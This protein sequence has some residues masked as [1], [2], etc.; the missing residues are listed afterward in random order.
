MSHK[1]GIPRRT[2]RERVLSLFLAAVL[3]LGMAPELV[4]PASADHWADAYL[5][6][7]VDWGVMRADQI[8]NPDARLTRA[9]FMAIVNRAYGYKE[10]GPMPF[11]DVLPTDWFY[12]DVAIAYTAGYMGGTSDN[13]ASPNNVLTREMAVCILARNMMMKDTPGE[14]LTFAD[15][16]DISGWAKGLVKTAVDNYIVDGY[17]DNRFGPQDAITKGQ[18]AA[19]VTRCVG[20]PLNEPGSYS[21]GDVFGNVTVTSPNVTLRNTTI[22]GDLYVSGGVGLGGVLLENVKVLGR[23]IVSGTGESEEGKAS[24]IM[25]NVSA[26]EL[27]VDNMRNRYVTVRA[28][29]VTEIAKT[30][31]RTNAYL[32]DNNTDTKGLM[33]ITLEGEPG[34]RLDLAGRIKTVVDKTP[35]S[36]IQVAKGAVQ[37]ITVDEKATNAVIQLNRNTEVKE[38]NLDVAAN[39]NGEGDIGKLNVNAPGST[40]TMLPDDI[41][42]RPGITGN[43]NG[44]VMDSAAAEES[45]LDPRLLSGFPVASD[46]AP[47][48]FRAD[49]SCNKR[50]TVYWAV[51]NI[52]DGSVGAE[53]L[54]HP[55]AYGSRAIRSG[56]VAVPAGNTTVSTQVTGLTVGGSYYLSAVMVDGRDRRSPVKVIS[57]T[58]PDNSVP[59][60]AQG[61]P[62]MSLITDSMAQVTVMPTKTCKLYYAVLPKGAMAPTVNDMRS[63]SVVGNLGYGIVDVV[64]NT[65]RVINVSSRLEELKDYTLYLWL[66]DADGA[67]SSA[68]I[69]V[70][71]RTVDM[72]PPRFVIAPHE[73]GPVQAT[74]VPL[75][76]ALNEAGIIYWAVVAEGDVYPKYNPQNPDDNE[77]INGNQQAKLDSDYAKLQVSTGMNALR[78]GRV[79]AQANT[80]VA[81]N[82]TGLQA[83]KSYDLYYVARDTAGN[84]SVKVEK[85]TIHTLDN[86]RPVARQYFSDYSGQDN[87]QNPMPNTDIILEF[88]ESVRSFVDVA[89]ED[90]TVS[91]KQS[92]KDLY[93]SVTADNNPLAKALQDCVML[94]Q[95]TGNGRP[96]PVKHKYDPKD[97]SDDWVIDFTKARV[98]MDSGKMLLTFPKDSLKLASG[99]TYYFRLSNIKDTSNA[100]N[101]IMPNPVTY[102]NMADG[103]HKI[104]R[105]TTVFAQVSLNNLNLGAA[106]APVKDGKAVNLDLT[107]RMSPQSTER[108]HERNSYDLYLWS[109]TIL[110][111]NLYYRIVKEDEP[112]TSTVDKKYW[113]GDDSN[114]VGTP[115]SKGWLYLGASGEVNPQN[116]EMAGKSLNGDFNGLK[117]KTFPPLKNLG[118]EYDYEFVIELTEMEGSTVR[119]TWNGQ[120]YFDIYAAAGV[121]STLVTLSRGL[122]KDRWEEYKALGLNNGG[123]VSIGISPQD[124]DYLRIRQL[125]TD[126]KL[127]EFTKTYPSFAETDIGDTFATIRLN[128]DRAGKIYYVVAPVGQITTTV[129]DGN[130]EYSDKAA[131]DWTGMSGGGKGGKP[132]LTDMGYTVSSP[133][134][135][136]IYR[137]TEYSGNSLIQTGVVEY[138][139]GG[140]TYELVLNASTKQSLQPNT[141]Y[142]AYFVVQGTAQEYSDV[143]CYKFKTTMVNRP[144]IMLDEAGGGLVNVNTTNV[145]GDLDYVI[146]TSA[147]LNL[148]ASLKRPL[149][150][151]NA[152]VLPTAYEDYTVLDAILNTYYDSNARAGNKVADAYFA[153]AG[154]DGYSVFDIYADDSI[155]AIVKTLIQQ[156]NQNTPTGG[157]NDVMT[158]ANTPIY[159]NDRNIKD[160]IKNT[161]YAILVVGRHPS[162][163][164]GLTASYTFKGIGGVIIPDQDPPNATEDSAASVWEGTAKGTYSGTVTVRF[165]KELYWV[166]DRNSKT[167]LEVHQ[168][169]ATSC[170][171]DTSIDIIN[172]VSKAGVTVANA[173]TINHVTNVLSFSYT[174]MR[175]GQSFSFVNQGMLCNYDRVP[176]T[177]QLIC[178]LKDDTTA[179]GVIGSIKGVYMEI[180][181]GGERVAISPVIPATTP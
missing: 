144:K 33:H 24:V 10:V 177:N 54:I 17:A 132:D 62:Y 181:W 48:G 153:P 138:P 110:K 129:S 130:A 16:R 140:N 66:T 136:S 111:Y 46:V 41:Y 70:Q 93:D 2:W 161:P 120:V 5:D 169:C 11:V 133:S 42:I 51:S 36:V 122:N 60:F 91:D 1:T 106:D 58:T 90:G 107:F 75:S 175:P 81:L 158:E 134:K 39:V 47:T 105:F 125:F 100:G 180:T 156:R 150:G 30:T 85:I 135:L 87:T 73:S 18:M 80:E 22:S 160:M 84:Y 92:W 123:I 96:A 167:A 35:D 154:S 109:D 128:M 65:E 12:D 4:L 38:L 108:V 179:T 104:P 57:F 176:T 141:E 166:K 139:G 9:E 25:R 165:D 98:E 147:N 83:E 68:I 103:G 112:V 3:L 119:E 149:K 173:E 28:D 52:S 79:N 76:A 71:F 171:K 131:W 151:N 32:E 170:D 29:G 6:Q 163:D 77:T 26:N 56:S 155:K 88:S 8:S 164:E 86:S 50:G 19:L 74:S 172:Y 44:V 82:I 34:T 127:P 27:L 69:P 78:S 43:I 178:T 114:K 89:N 95:D 14:D 152:K 102:V 97:T 40:V 101:E 115:D 174:D 94:Y 113:L 117:D 53:D 61:Y 55:P 162:S 23:I 146:Y 13:T 67:N 124:N 63:A 49:F 142:F 99:G 126:T 31:V 21:L 45:S 15:S 148:V 64:K 157:G 7:L 168:N 143:Y 121:S 137:R 59:A 145:P 159:I 72:T 118:E 20:N 37:T 116:G